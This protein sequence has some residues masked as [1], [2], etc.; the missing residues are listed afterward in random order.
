MALIQTHSLL[1]GICP[2]VLLYMKTEFGIIGMIMNFLL[3]LSSSLAITAVLGSQLEA[4]MVSVRRIL[5]YCDNRLEGVGDKPRTLPSAAWPTRGEIEFESVIASYDQNLPPALRNVSLK[6]R[7]GEKIG[8]VGRTG[9]G[10]SSLASVLIGFL[11]LDAGA[12][13]IDNVDISMVEINELRSRIATIP[14]DPIAFSGTVRENLDPDGVFDTSELVRV[15]QDSC[16]AHSF[17]TPQDAL[18]ATLVDGG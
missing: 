12:V 16:F 18:E 3:Q 15:L 8:I 17:V 5:Q 14:Q 7:S 9:A 4:E 1:I 10:K 13:R 6:I 2:I 11:E